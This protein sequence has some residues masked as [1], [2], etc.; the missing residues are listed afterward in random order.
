MTRFVKS[1]ISTLVILSLVAVLP[2]ETTV[3][4]D[5]VEFAIKKDSDNAVFASAEI[6]KKKKKGKKI[7]K[8][9]KKKKKGFF[10]KWKGAK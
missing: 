2:A 6:K 4:A 8:K 3:K 5:Q 9:G 10:S 1:V 7:G